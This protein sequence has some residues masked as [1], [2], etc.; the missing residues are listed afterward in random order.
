MAWISCTDKRF[1]SES[2]WKDKTLTIESQIIADDLDILVSGEMRLIDSFLIISDAY[3]EPLYRIYKITDNNQLEYISGF[4]AKGEGPNEF[5]FNSYMQ[6]GEDRLSILDQTLLRNYFIDF[7]KLANPDVD[8][9]M[10]AKS[11]KNAANFHALIEVSDDLY[12]GNGSFHDGMF[13]FYCDDSVIQTHIPFP[14]DGISASHIQKGLAYQGACLKQTGGN[15]LVFAGHNGHFLEIYNIKDT[16]MQKVFSDVYE[17]P[18][19]TPEDGGNFIEVN[20]AQDDLLGFLDVFATSEY[21][22][23][24]YCGKK[25]G[26]NRA[27]LANIIYV[28]NWNGERIKKYILDKELSG[29]CVNK[30]NTKIYGLYTDSNDDR[31]KI[32]LFHLPQ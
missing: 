14:E 30:E 13:A 2:V 9:F 29:I 15:K 4:G 8:S 25:Y 23:A 5:L 18:R 20:F 1:T 17:F 19:Y 11:V 32:V 31:L 16:L 21:I 10:V 26:D 28:Y 24:L 22:Y 27:F 12:V 7:H 6:I 3:N